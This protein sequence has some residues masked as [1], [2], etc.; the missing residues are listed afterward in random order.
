MFLFFLS[1]Y[2]VIGVAVSAFMDR[3]KMAHQ[4]GICQE[5]FLNYVVMP[6]FKSWVAVFPESKM[7]LSNLEVYV[8]VYDSR[9]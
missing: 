2:D 4:K 3:E 7:I 8:Y 6:L 9:K 5:G 1:T